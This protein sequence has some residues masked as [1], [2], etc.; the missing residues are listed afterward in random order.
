M[1]RPTISMTRRTFSAALASLPAFAA[2]SDWP[3]WRGPTRDGRVSGVDWPETLQGDRLRQKW[4][5][6]LGPSYSGPIVAADRIF[7]TETVDKKREVVKA[8]DRAT[9]RELWAVS[10][11]GAISVP[12]FAK[13]NGDWIRSTPAYDGERLFVGGI[14]DVLVCLS[15]ADG[16]E[17]WRVLHG[18][19]Y[20][21]I[22]RP[23]LA[24]GLLFVGTGYDRPLIHA[25]R[26]GGSGDVTATH[27]AWTLAKGAPNTPSM[28]VVD[29]LLYCVSDAG[30]ASAIEA[31]TG[32]VAWTERLGGNF[33]ASILHADGRLYLQ[34]EEGMG[35]VLKPGRAFEVLAR[36]DLGERSLASHA[37]ED[38]ALYIRTK[39]SLYRIGEPPARRRE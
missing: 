14:R 38:G 29:D 35:F 5:I 6:E 7:T 33:S 18:E 4:R 30:I 19:G 1:V 21:V 28:V 26:T 12:F 20:S 34:N 25:I 22:P 37:V 36:N 24:H 9:G 32:Q 15:A 23:V 27:L 2:A 8:I 39:S 17:L 11:D 16:R 3:Q 10:W 31:R 13:S